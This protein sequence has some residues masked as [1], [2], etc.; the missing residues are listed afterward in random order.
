[1]YQQSFVVKLLTSEPEVVGID[2]PEGLGGQKCIWIS[3]VSEV[4][5]LVGNAE[6]TTNSIRTI[7]EPSGEVGHVS[8]VTY[9][10]GRREKQTT[11]I[12]SSP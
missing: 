5:F 10:L 4:D 1:M 2:G 12:A 8:A 6:V 11:R 7:K 9:I 3:G